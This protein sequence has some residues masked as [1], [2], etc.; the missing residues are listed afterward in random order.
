MPVFTFEIVNCHFD[1]S[2][3]K[4]LIPKIKQI[5]KAQV[6]NIMH[7]NPRMIDIFKKNWNQNDIILETEQDLFSETHSR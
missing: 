4:S 7:L 2:L 5:N 1:F 3:N 6:E